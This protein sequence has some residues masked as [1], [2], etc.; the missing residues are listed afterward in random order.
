MS[1][2][3]FINLP[4]GLIAIQGIKTQVEL[5]VFKPGLESLKQVIQP[6]RYL[7][8]AGHS[9]PQRRALL[10]LNLAPLQASSSG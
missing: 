3:Y 7:L 9:R 2:I 6:G 5:S 8:S 10:Q 4:A 1:A